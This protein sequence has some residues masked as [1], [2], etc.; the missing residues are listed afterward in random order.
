[1]ATKKIRL[2]C[3]LKSCWIISIMG[4]LPTNKL[5]CGSKWDQASPWPA[6]GSDQW[7]QIEQIETLRK[8]DR[9]KASGQDG[10]KKNKKNKEASVCLGGMD[11][12]AKH[13]FND[14]VHKRI[15]SFCLK[16]NKARSRWNLI[17]AGQQT[18]C[19]GYTDQNWIINFLTTSHKTVYKCHMCLLSVRNNTSTT[20]LHLA[21]HRWM[22]YG[23]K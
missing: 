21:V 4:L 20:T 11:V 7:C 18:G 22:L 5:R 3:N 6:G 8:K 19:K 16:W 13:K 15:I 12:H 17:P 2:I 10:R 1:M 23:S 9:T 14:C